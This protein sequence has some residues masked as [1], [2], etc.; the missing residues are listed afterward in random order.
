MRRFFLLLIG[1][2]LVAALFVGTAYASVNKTNTN[3]N[4]STTP[5]LLPRVTCSGDGCNGLD[6]EQ[7]GCAADAYTVKVSGGKVACQANERSVTC[8]GR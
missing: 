6:P 5:H 1:A 2:V 3:A 4:V 8:L 7:A